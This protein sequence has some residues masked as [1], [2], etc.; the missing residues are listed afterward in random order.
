MKTI[1][2]ALSI[3]VI[4]AQPSFAEFYKYLDKHGKAH[5][6]DDPSKIPEEYRDVKKISGKI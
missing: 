5:F 4:F 3:L 6:V 2:C 1:L